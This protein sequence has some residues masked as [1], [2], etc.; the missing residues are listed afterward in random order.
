MKALSIRQPWA[1]LILHAGK[2]IENRDWKDSNP[3]LYDARRLKSLATTGDG[4]FLIHTGKSMTRGEY[5]EAADYA[6]TI[7][8]QIALPP[9]DQLPRGG[10][11]GI[12][13]L[14]DIVLS[15]SSE[16]FFGRIG[17]VIADA[18]PLPFRPLRGA[19]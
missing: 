10:I 12:A 16:W 13:R 19:L 18:A 1:W 8:R 4:H 15:H 3:A 6:R 5:E 14:T 7:D 9:Y 17:L 11:V 2:D